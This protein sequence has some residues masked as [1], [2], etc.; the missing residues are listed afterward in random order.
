VNSQH[1]YTTILLDAGQ[2]LD[3]WGLTILFTCALY[4]AAIMIAAE[5]SALG[6]EQ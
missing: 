5:L 1:T 6:G 2:F 4:A 3:V